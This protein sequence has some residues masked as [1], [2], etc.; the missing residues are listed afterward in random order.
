MGP[1]GPGKSFMMSF[2]PNIRAEPDK[3]KQQT[4]G[5][6]QLKIFI[7]GIF[8]AIIQPCT[9]ATGDKNAEVLLNHADLLC[10]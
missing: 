10:Q 9:Q 3:Q 2:Q 5:R 1:L 6:N 8:Y 4:S 7:E